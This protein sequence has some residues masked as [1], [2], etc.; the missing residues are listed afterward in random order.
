MM[1]A[2][3][4]RSSGEQ[5]GREVESTE[6]TSVPEEVPEP[7]GAA[8]RPKAWTAVEE[9]SSARAV[10]AASSLR[11]VGRQA[12][13][14]TPEQWDDWRWQLAH[15][16]RTL[17]DFQ[18]VLEL[19]G[20]EADGLTIAC[21][22]FAVAATPY[23]VSLMERDNPNC[24][25]RR[26]VV[27]SVKELII[28][29]TDLEDP[30][31][32][33]GDTKVPG[34][35]HRYPDRVL[36][37]ASDRCASYC[38]YCTRSRLVGNSDLRPV[39]ERVEP[40]AQYVAA[41]PEV[42]DVLVSG[43]DPLLLGELALGTIIRRFRAIPH[44][45]IVRIGT[46]VP[47][48]LPQRITPRL[49]RALRMNGAYFLSV[50]FSHPREITPEVERALATIA[51]GGVVMGSQTV[52]LRGINDHP[53]TLKRLFHKLLKNRVRPYYLYQCD[54]VVGASHFRTSVAAG[55]EIM[56]KLRGF[57]SG[58]AVPTFVIDAPGGGGKTPVTPDY[59][60]E[61]TAQQVTIRNYAGNVYTYPEV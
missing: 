54:P 15:R 37:L 18:S 21:K 14:A 23:F 13:N 4:Q 16:L 46:R 38:R 35:V 17:E 27:P 53:E 60:V 2:S 42:R 57:T 40:A 59:I 7:P 52:L 34:L 39:S 48:Y 44:V 33:E 26:Q 55:I 5:S 61:H 19:S 32:E 30:C 24:P 31:G 1:D 56:R 51:D 47:A 8:A 41:H 49:V 9:P 11:L 20:E 6:G 22:K 43:G 50:H 45:E 29:P 58:Y 3:S 10:A 25:I 28:S 36:F 12:F